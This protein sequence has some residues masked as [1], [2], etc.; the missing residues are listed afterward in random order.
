MAGGRV[1]VRKVT[2]VDPVLAALPVSVAVTV[3]I[4]GDELVSVMARQS[5]EPSL[6]VVQLAELS[7]A[8]GAEMVRGPA[9]ST[10]LP[11]LTCTMKVVLPLAPEKS[12]VAAAGV[13]V[14]VYGS[15]ALYELK[16]GSAALIVCA[17]GST[18]DGMA[19]G[20]LTGSR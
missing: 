10:P 5:P 3:M 11:S 12:T 13:T 17:T 14:T 7:V 2:V 15:L 9:R 8:P 16:C 18:V 1:G 19:V 6:L 4:P 20:P